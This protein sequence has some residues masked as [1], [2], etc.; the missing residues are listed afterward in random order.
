LKGRSIPF[1]AGVTS[2]QV[3]IDTDAQYTNLEE[4]HVYLREDQEFDGVLFGRDANH[5]TIV[6]YQQDEARTALA[7]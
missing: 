4:A 2:R 5:S 1:H 3:R 7:P 6:W